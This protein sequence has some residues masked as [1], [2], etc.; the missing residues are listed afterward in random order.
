MTTTRLAI[1]ASGATLSEAI[2]RADAEAVRHWTVDGVLRPFVRAAVEARSKAPEVEDEETMVRAT[3]TYQSVPPTDGDGMPVEL[4]G[5]GYEVRLGEVV[6]RTGDLAAGV[7][8]WTPPVRE[9]E[10]PG[11]GVDP[12]PG[13]RL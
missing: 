13:G 11:P 8:R 1:T 6:D 5:F 10:V 3:V 4:D 9:V 7:G 12:V 2:D